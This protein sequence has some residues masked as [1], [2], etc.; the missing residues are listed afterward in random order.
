MSE[1]RGRLIYIGGV[2]M[3]RADIIDTHAHLDDKK[4]AKDRENVLK[5]ASDAGVT[6]IITVGND[7]TAS[8][9]ACALAEQYPEI[10]AAVGIHPHE[11]KEVV[12]R[13]LEGLR[14]LAENSKVLAWG[15]IG[16]DYHY[17]FSPRDCQQDV[18]RK[19]LEIA[20]ELGLPV[21]IHDREAHE[22]VLSILKD[23]TGLKA[24]AVHCFSGDMA[25]AE[26][27]LNRGYYLGIGG[28]LT[29]PKNNKLRDVV[30]KAPLNH[31]L[32]ETDCPY[33]APQPWRGKRNEPAFMTAVLDEIAQIKEISQE[34]IAKATTANAIKAFWG[35]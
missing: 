9:Y 6:R 2:M 24:V 23:F 1:M 5:R 7:F 25:I 21:I 20:G 30:K 34:E 33:L 19:Q 4:F 27:C 15:E 13:T 28:T 29:F 22:D 11:A 16:L 35:G 14:I 32:L 18:F 8:R 10:Y 26:E 31:L 17:D 3:N 12:P